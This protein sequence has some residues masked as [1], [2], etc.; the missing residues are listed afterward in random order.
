MESIIVTANNKKEL[1]LVKLFLEQK[2]VD[3]Q[4]LKQ[5]DKPKRKIKMTKEE[6]GL[7]L[8]RA[9]KEENIPL[10]DEFRKSLLV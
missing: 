10:T 4:V 5:E 3:F 7:M 8:D 2:K 9:R 1:S 6:Y